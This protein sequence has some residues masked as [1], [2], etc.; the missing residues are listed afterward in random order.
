MKH[1]LNFNKNQNVILICYNIQ[2][3]IF[4]WME[5]TI[6][7][8]SINRILNKPESSSS[9]LTYTWQLFQVNALSN[10]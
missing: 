1:V 3:K 6:F 8:I 2:R 4:F 5:F 10:K 9:N 7:R